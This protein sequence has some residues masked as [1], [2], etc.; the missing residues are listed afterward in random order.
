VF[1]RFYR[2]DG[3]ITSG[4]GLG[5]AIAKELAAVMGG[6]IGLDSRPGRTVFTLKLP[7]SST[8]VDEPEPALAR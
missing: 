1:E 2:G 5:L 6:E 3:T 7:R 4:S 8:P